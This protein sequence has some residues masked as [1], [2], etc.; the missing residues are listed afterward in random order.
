MSCLGQIDWQAFDWQSFAT[1]TTG[2]LAVAAAFIIGRR[3]VDIQHRQ[4]AI[5]EAAL[6][7]DLFDRRYKVFER[8]AQFL[9]EISQTDG[10]SPDTTREFVDASGTSGFLFGPAVQDSLH[11]IRG[12]VPRDGVGFADSPHCDA[13]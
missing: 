10:P 5:Q 4:T 2:V 3:Q 13:R 6:R 12:R 7:L 9:R 8:T 1:L 11:E